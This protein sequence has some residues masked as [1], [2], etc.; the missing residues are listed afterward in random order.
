M[1]SIMKVVCTLRSV[2]HALESPE[3]LLYFLVFSQSLN[4]FF[5]NYFF[6][7]FFLLLLSISYHNPFFLCYEAGF[8]LFVGFFSLNVG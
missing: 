7:F 2:S 1:N 8:F 3:P 4:F 5:S 6:F